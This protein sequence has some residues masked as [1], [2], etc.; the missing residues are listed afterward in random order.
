MRGVFFWYELAA[1][2]KIVWVN[3]KVHLHQAASMLDKI[4]IVLVGT[5]HSGNIGSAARAMKVMG[6]SQMSLVS[7]ECRVDAQAIALAA[8]ASEIA[9]NAEHYESLNAAV[10]DC[11][12]V[13]GCSA[14]S[15]S[16]DWPLV[17]AHQGAQ[18]LIQAIQAQEQPVALVFGRERTGLTNEELQQCHYHVNIPANPEYSSLN[19]AMA[20]QILCYEVRMA[21]LNRSEDLMPNTSEAIYPQHQELT[22]FYRHLERVLFAT[23]FISPDRPNLILQKLQRLFTR[24]RVQVTELNILRGFLTAIEKSIKVNK[25]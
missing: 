21:S 15:R 17:T 23:Q 7:P 14:R 11:S 12:L 5:S 16:L 20:V 1:E 8:G 3:N 18:L 25:E 6:L 2:K 9:L 13:L 22:A 4:K 10:A 19:L 24:A